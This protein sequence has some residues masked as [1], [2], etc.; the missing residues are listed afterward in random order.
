L[1]AGKTADQFHQRLKDM[2]ITHIYVDWKEINRHRAQGGYGFTDFVTPQRFLDWTQ[3][4]VLDR[5]AP[6]ALE[7]NPPRF[8]TEQELYSVR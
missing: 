8:A 1:A 4:G 5:P 3:A 7:S 2:G 6:I